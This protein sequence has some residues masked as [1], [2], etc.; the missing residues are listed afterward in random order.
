[1]IS[2]DTWL[3]AIQS[4]NDCIDINGLHPNYSKLGCRNMIA[5]MS[6][7]FSSSL[8]HRFIPRDRLR[9][10]IRQVITNSIGKIS[11]SDTYSPIT[12]SENC[13]KSFEYCISD[14]LCNS[15]PL[16]SQQFGFRKHTSTLMATTIL[17]EIIIDYKNAVNAVYVAFIDLSKA[18][19]KV[20][21]FPNSVVIRL[22]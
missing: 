2:Y 3:N 12:I 21:L 17:K 19:D 16:S 6:R 20:N 5:S 8:N 10:E 7:I 15:L 1:M 14:H 4:I 13:L 11:D 22:Q 18:F 9:G